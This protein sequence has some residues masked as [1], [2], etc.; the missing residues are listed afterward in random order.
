MKG[1][2]PRHAFDGLSQKLCHPVFHFAGRL[3]GK[4]HRKYFVG[5]GFAHIQKMRNPG[6]QRLG[7]AG[8]STSQHQNRT[9]Q[10]FNRLA[11]R[12]VQF[13][14]IP[15][16]PGRH[17]ARRQRSAFKGISVIKTVHKR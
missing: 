17:R 2:H 4:G 16:W 6:C 7:F 5:T 8:S 12:R 10:S 3:V 9:I 13:V 11:L 15:R 1:T 14:K